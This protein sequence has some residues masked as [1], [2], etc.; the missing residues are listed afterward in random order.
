VNWRPEIAAAV[1]SEGSFDISG[2][3]VPRRL[4][5]LTIF[6]SMPWLW[7]AWSKIPDVAWTLD[8]NDEGYSEAVIA[9]PC[10]HQ[11]RVEVGT[12]ET[13]D[14][15]YARAVAEADDPDAVDDAAFRCPRSYLFLGEATYV[16]NSPHR[17]PPV[18]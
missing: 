7:R 3:K 8:V 18:A 15:D 13:C 6:R 17:P 9:C 11:P 2:R 4:G 14:D 1:P 5:V 12:I 16:A 10:G